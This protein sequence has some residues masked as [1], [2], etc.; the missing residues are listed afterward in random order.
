MKIVYRLLPIIYMLFIWTLS[1][2]PANAVVEL[3]NEGLDGFIKESLHLIE[4]G[5]LYI[6]LFFAGL[7]F[8]KFTPVISFIFMGIAILYG[9][10]DEIHQSFVP[11]RSATWIDFIKDTIGVLVA[12]HFMHHAYFNGKFTK[13][14]LLLRNFE[15]WV[16]R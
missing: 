5:I 13:L 4:F 16:K 7:T 15:G 8:K 3:P 12:A 1:S 9:A 2:M 6:L 10:V 14:S 11:Y